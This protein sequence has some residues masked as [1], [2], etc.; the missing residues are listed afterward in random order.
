MDYQKLSE[1][2]LNQI[3]GSSSALG[4]GSFK[5]RDELRRA[6][7]LQR[8]KIKAGERADRNLARAANKGDSQ[9]VNALLA[10]KKALGDGLA[11]APIGIGNSQDR[12]ERVKDGVL[13]G[14]DFRHG[15]GNI[16]NT[17]PAEGPIANAPPPIEKTQG[18][19][20]T[21][22]S[23]NSG[24]PDSIQRPVAGPQT[25]PEGATT[26]LASPSP[27]LT[28]KDLKSR[29]A[30]ASDLDRSTLVQTDPAA[31]ERAYKRGESIG[32]SRDEVNRRQ[33]W[34]KPVLASEF[35]VAP[36]PNP[37]AIGSESP[38]SFESLTEGIPRRKKDSPLVSA[39]NQNDKPTSISRESVFGSSGSKAK[40]TRSTPKE[41][42]EVQGFGA[43]VADDVK[44][45]YDATQ[46]IRDIPGGIRQQIR[47]GALDAVGMARK[48]Y[49]AAQETG[50]S[51][52]A[53]YLPG[54]VGEW[55]KKKTRGNF[56]ALGK[57]S[58]AID[59]S[60]LKMKNAITRYAQPP[61]NPPPR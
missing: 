16:G 28:P 19:G 40:S 24:I 6:E 53:Q 57:K 61:S 4:E 55:A 31:R 5:R 37:V 60:I 17:A 41:N 2:D 11:Q 3:N 39:Y 12:D 32:V 59:D 43:A 58:R 23:D 26:T 36:E 44:S 18:G 49:A 21:W 27:K 48:T 30:F 51:M 42:G 50:P 47:Y 25:A 35:S 46:P 10:Y 22:D 29:Q 14:A 7:S 45:I 56:Q 1:R 15:V 13:K 33:Q 54:A 9:T 20:P 8:N 52:L 34:S 38:S